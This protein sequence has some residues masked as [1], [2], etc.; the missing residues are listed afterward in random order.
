MNMPDFNT[1]TD[2]DLLFYITN[3]IEEKLAMDGIDDID[4]GTGFGQR[5]MSIGIRPGSRIIVTVEV[6]DY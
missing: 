6:I 4:T 1:M 5:D 3:A 2:T